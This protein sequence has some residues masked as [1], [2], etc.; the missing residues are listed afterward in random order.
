MPIGEL[1][2]LNETLPGVNADSL[3]RAAALLRERNAIDAELAHLI[4]RPMTSGHL[5]EWIA[6]Q[7]FDIELEAS[8]FAEA[9]DGRFRS[10]TLRGRTVNIKWYL[11]REGPPIG[12]SA[13]PATPTPGS[14][15][16]PSRAPGTP[17]HGWHQPGC[18]E[19]HPTCARIS[20]AA[21]SHHAAR[22]DPRVRDP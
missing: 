15:P 13:I 7:V 20:L 9:I 12:C 4:Q 1:K 11:K 16:V 17:R 6:A 3:A 8:A 21:R 5:G 10:G 19:N 22:G 2:L 18:R 14:C